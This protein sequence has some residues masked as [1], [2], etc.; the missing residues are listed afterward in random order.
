M[1]AYDSPA[2][3]VRTAPEPVLV[4]VEEA[5]RMLRLSRTETFR[6]I[7]AGDIESVKIGQRRRVSVASVRAYAER[8]IAAQNPEQLAQ[9]R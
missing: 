9:F 6:L 3:G 2:V 4:H 7:G 5:A 8:L 1:Q